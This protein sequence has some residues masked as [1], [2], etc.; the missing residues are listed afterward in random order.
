M[1]IV[2]DQAQD[3]LMFPFYY[4]RLMDREEKNVEE[5]EVEE[6]E[7]DSKN[8]STLDNKK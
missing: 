4:L 5:N 8:D 1:V 6:T 2:V 7:M 3:N